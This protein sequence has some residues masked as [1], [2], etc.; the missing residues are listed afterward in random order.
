VAVV[1]AVAGALREG[2]ER[3]ADQPL[4][5][6][7]QALLTRHDEGRRLEASV[8]A[9]ARALEATGRAG[10]DTVRR[11]SQDGDAALLVGLLARRA[12]IDGVDA[13]NFF[14][15]GEAMLLARLAGCDRAT[16]AQ[17]VAAFD[18]M[19]GPGAADR[20]IDVFDAI[21]DERV[22]NCRRWMRLDRHYRLA[23][24]MLEQSNG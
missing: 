10:D 3:G 20:V 2:L 11:L 6:A 16:A 12:G 9:L 8:A 4:E 5:A 13:W 15:G 21:D 19:F 23:R 1:H 22:E 24:D 7:A 17:M 18:S 14:S